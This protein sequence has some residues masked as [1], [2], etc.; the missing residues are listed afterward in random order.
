MPAKFTGSLH[1]YVDKYTDKSGG[2]DACWMWTGPTNGKGYGRIALRA[3]RSLTPHRVQCERFNG[4]IP[5]G[6]EVDHLC[7]VAGD[8][9]LVLDCPHRSCVNPK[10]LEAVTPRDNVLRSNAPMAKFAAQTHCKNGHSLGEDGDVYIAKGGGRV[11]RVCHREWDRIR[12][13]QNPE[14][15]RSVR[16]RVGS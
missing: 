8:C 5:A 11:C 7:H 15:R 6:H 12:Y 2:P 14:R 13:Q 1:D 10:H 3:H 9:T 16:S 4:P